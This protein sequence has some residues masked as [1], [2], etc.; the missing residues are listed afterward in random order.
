MQVSIFTFKISF[1]GSKVFANNKSFILPSW[2][3]KMN[4]S[5]GNAFNLN[6]ELFNPL[7]SLLW[8]FPI[9]PANKVSPV[10]KKGNFVEVGATWVIAIV[11]ESSVCPGVCK[12]HIANSPILK[13]YNSSTVLVW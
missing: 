11:Q 4:V 13:G 2:L 10:N 1:L 7:K 6:N 12:K 3:G 9:D 5:L 8:T